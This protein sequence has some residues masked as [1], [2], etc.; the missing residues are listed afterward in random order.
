MDI[1][2][3]RYDNDRFNITPEGNQQVHIAL[4]TNEPDSSR[5]PCFRLGSLEELQQ[6]Q[7]RIWDHYVKGGAGA[8]K[9]ADEPGQKDSGSS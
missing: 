5:H 2:F 9:T 8:P 6:L 7:Q 3:L 1:Q 4:G